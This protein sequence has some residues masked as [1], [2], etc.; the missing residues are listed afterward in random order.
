MMPPSGLGCFF[1]CPLVALV[2]LRPAVLTPE[3]VASRVATAAPSSLGVR[4]SEMRKGG[5][6]KRAS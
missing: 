2:F 5:T 4:G 1:E 3:I 6:L